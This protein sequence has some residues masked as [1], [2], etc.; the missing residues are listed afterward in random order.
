MSDEKRDDDMTSVSHTHPHTGETFGTVYERGP[1]TT[2]GGRTD[3][4]AATETMRDV[5]HTPPH[6]DEGAADVWSRGETRI[7]DAASATVAT[8]GDH[9]VSDDVDEASDE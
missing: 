6:D 1:A 7:T 9:P 5:D 8:D 3:R 4:D 2:D